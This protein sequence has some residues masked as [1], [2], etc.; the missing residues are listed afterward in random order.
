M[1]ECAFCEIVAGREPACLVDD[2]RSLHGRTIMPMC[3][4][5]PDRPTATAAERYER[6]SSITGMRRVVCCA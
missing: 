6:T 1:G 4:H 2:V 5:R 3:R